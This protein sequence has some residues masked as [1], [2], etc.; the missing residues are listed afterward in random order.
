MIVGKITDAAILKKIEHQPKRTAGFKQLVRELGLHGDA[1]R[2]LAELLQHLV[3]SGQLLQVDSERFALPHAAAGRNLVVGR[4]S[5]HRDGFGFVIPDASSLDERLKARLAGDIFIPPPAIGSAMHGDRVL[6]E[7]G[8]IRP[9]G[10]A[11]GRIVRPVGRAHTT[12]VGTFH[13]GSRRNY[14]T[15][16]DQKITQEIIIPPGMELPEA[17]DARAPQEGVIPTLS[18]AKGRDPA[19]SGSRDGA[20]AAVSRKKLERS[21]H[22]VL[23]SEAA[24]HAEWDDLEGVVVDVEITDWPTATQNPRGRVVEI[25]GYADDFGVDVEIIIR[26]FHLPHRFPTEVLDVAQDTEAV[27]PA[28]A[29]HKRRDFRALPIVTIDGETARD[30]DDAV[31]VR[32]LE[33]GNFE[34]QVHIADVAYYV[35][36]GSAL[37]QEAR[38]RGTSVYFPDRAVPMLPLELSTDIC[39][40]R[41]HVD[42]LVMS[43]VMEMDHRGEILGYELCDGIIR[44]AERMTYTDVNAVLEGDP[45]TRKRYA[46]LVDLFESMRELAMI[47]N[48]KRERRGSI[49]F[50]LPEPVIEFDEFGLMKSITRSERNIAN[51]IIEEFMLSA[52]ECVA[53][54]L[55]NKRVGS[56][57]RIHEK[58]DAKRVYDFEVIAATFGYSLGVGALPIQRMQLKGDRRASYGTGRHARE[59]EIPKEVHI[60]PRMYQK[61]TE[62]IAGKPEERILSYLMLRSLKQARYSEENLGHFALAATT[63]TH[64]TSPI[65]R[66]PDLIVHRILKEVL[67]DSAERWDGEV[68]VGSSAG[69]QTAAQEHSGFRDG[70]AA[71]SPWSKRRDHAEHRR[72]VEPAGGPISLEELHDIAEESSQAERRADDAERELME[73]K[74]VK[75]MQE[76]VGDDFDG[77]IISVTKFGFFVELTDLFVEGLVPLSTL[78]DD[79]YTYHENT[80]EIIGQHSRRIY[81]LGQKIRVIVDRIDPVEKKIQFAVLEPEEQPS[82]KRPGRR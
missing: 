35:T 8:T 7:V 42:R 28:R 53:D 12:V 44:S 16:I 24:R 77:L 69:I 41:P 57:Y 18:E 17:T 58:P 39:S 74:K 76:R 40:L 45:S 68:A 23:G 10:R 11:E 75:F 80:R 2:E 29:V 71:A 19:R 61:L 63:Y 73:W 70:G 67:R 43:C 33:N 52:N 49:D 21:P 55:E 79:R 15:P 14:V 47:L 64:F 31:T 66:Y 36:E 51:R 72:R 48:R 62:K 65:R 3:A 25:L 22:R 50:D 37:D 4:L 38:L 13:Y 59:V 81:R 5:M 9:D 54:Y 46:R 26:K 1:R 30:F 78:T 82:R 56:L 20:R 32:K 27:I 60:T 34:L 6:V